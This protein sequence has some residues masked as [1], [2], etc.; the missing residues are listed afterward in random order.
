MQ[1]QRET[2]TPKEWTKVSYIQ[3]APA[4]FTLMCVGMIVM[5]QNMVFQM[6][7]SPAPTDHHI[8]EAGYIMCVVMGGEIITTMLVM[9]LMEVLGYNHKRYILA[10]RNSRI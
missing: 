4:V 5:F 2:K 8:S 6:F 10:K 7:L 9:A 3:I 1:L